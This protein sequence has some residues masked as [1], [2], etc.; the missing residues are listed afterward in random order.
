MSTT[1]SGDGHEQG[2]G[3]WATEGLPM[4]VRKELLERELSKLGFRKAGAS[5]GSHES[6][7]SSQQGENTSQHPQADATDSGHAD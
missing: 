6:G 5:A 7:P 3:S 4:S 2:A 1:K